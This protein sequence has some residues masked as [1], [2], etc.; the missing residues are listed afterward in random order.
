M[1]L[2]TV[3]AHYG[4]KWAWARTGAL[5]LFLVTGILLVASLTTTRGHASGALL[6]A[7]TGITV[8]H[9]LTAAG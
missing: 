1:D 6:Q 9:Q 5:I 8:F 7:G 3:K 2:Q 4:A